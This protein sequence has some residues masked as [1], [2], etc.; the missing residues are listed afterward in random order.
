MRNLLKSLTALAV[1]LV[2]PAA[3][4][5]NGTIIAERVQKLTRARHGSSWPSVPI[6]LD[7]TTRRGW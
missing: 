2:A 7:S 1:A 4:A 6:I 3:L 5:D